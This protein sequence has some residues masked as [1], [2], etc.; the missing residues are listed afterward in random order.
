MILLWDFYWPVVAAG[1]VIGIMMGMITFRARSTPFRRNAMLAAGAVAA[2][3]AAALW[4]GPLGTYSRL[5]SLIERNAR[6]ELNRLELGGV[7]AQLGRS[8]ALTRNLLL[9]GP[10]DNFQRE[11]LPRYM[12]EIPGVADVAWLPARGDY[13]LP[14]IAEAAIGALIAFLLG[15]FL[16][17]LIE[18]RRRARAEWSW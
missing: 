7:T 17:W 3:A 14:L 5:A 13:P 12:A 8:P 9:T 18:V 4:H 15:L 10:A 2:I 16:S 1:L 11:E 6:I